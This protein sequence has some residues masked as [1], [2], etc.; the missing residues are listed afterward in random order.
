[1][2]TN[3]ISAEMPDNKPPSRTTTSNDNV[4]PI[5]ITTTPIMN[6]MK[7]LAILS[8]IMIICYSIHVLCISF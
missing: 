1:M 3:I 8:D 4:I 7:N 5:A 2:L 6:T